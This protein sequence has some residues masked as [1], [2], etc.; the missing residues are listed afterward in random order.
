MSVS[1]A[2]GDT[3]LQPAHPVSQSTLLRSAAS[4]PIFHSLPASELLLRVA[5]PCGATL[6]CAGCAGATPISCI[7]A[8]A[9]ATPPLQKGPQ[10]LRIARS[11]AKAAGS[12]EVLLSFPSPAW[13]EKVP[14]RACR[15]LDPGD[16]QEALDSVCNAHA[17]VMHRTNARCA[18]SRR[19]LIREWSELAQVRRCQRI[20]MQSLRVTQEGCDQH[21]DL[22]DAATDVGL[23]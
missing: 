1:P 22:V 10:S 9:C 3:A 21:H 12:R 15:G 8:V 20:E 7:H 4:L 5:S 17:H 19:P 23:A 13:R 16:G 6:A 2:S 18:N 11:K 14:G